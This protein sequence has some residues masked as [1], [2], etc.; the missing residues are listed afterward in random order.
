MFPR[1]YVKNVEESLLSVKNKIFTDVQVCLS[2]L[3]AMFTSMFP[4]EYVKNV[5]ESL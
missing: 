5:E 3:V 1:E 2:V 4:R